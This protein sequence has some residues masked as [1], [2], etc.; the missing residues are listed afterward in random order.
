MTDKVVIEKVGPVK[1]PRPVTEKIDR[2][3]YE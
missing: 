1:A 2:D 3:I